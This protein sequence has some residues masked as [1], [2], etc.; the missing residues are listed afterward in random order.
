M[1]WGSMSWKGLGTIDF[2][3][4]TMTKEVYRD[5]LEK[6]LRQSARKVG[7]SRNFIFQQDNDPKHTAGIVTE[8]FKKH[9]INVLP[10]APQSPDLNPIEHLWSEMERRL[11]GRKP[12]NKEELKVM[13][14]NIWTEIDEE[15]KVTQNLVES[16]P[17][18]IA[19]VRKSKGGPT[20]Y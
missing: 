4:N 16:M 10:W 5:L 13:L 12:K 8:W 18:R 14:R 15:G 7:L 1:V 19:A 11:S 2:I 20:K 9:K 17:R 6:N 3:E